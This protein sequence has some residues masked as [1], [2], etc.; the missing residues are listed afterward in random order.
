MAASGHYP[1]KMMSF[2]SEFRLQAVRPIIDSQS[3]LKAELQTVVPDC[4]RT[5]NHF[6]FKS[7]FFKPAMASFISLKWTSG[8]PESVT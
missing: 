6:F 8:L 2:C 3:R 5:P 4:I 1:G 7:G